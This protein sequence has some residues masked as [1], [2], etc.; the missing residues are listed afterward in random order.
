MVGDAL[1]L[2]PVEAG[3]PFRLAQEAVGH[4]ALTEIRRQKEGQDREL[5]GA[6]YGKASGA[7]IVEQMLDRG[8]LKGYGTTKDA[9][10]A[11]VDA[12]LADPTPARDKLVIAPTNE[13]ARAITSAIRGGLKARGELQG[14]QPVQVAGALA[15]ETRELDL[16]IGDRVRFGKRHKAMGVSNGSI[17]VIEQIEE[18]TKGGHKLA[19]RL[20]S[21]IPGRDGRLVRVDTSKYQDLDHGYAGTVHKA[22]GQGKQTVYWH[23]EGGSADRHLG[24]VAFT[25]TKKTMHAFAS[26][27]GLD[28]LEKSL[29]DWRLKQ[30]AHE[31]APQA[32]SALVSPEQ[33]Q[34]L[35]A[36]LGALL[37]QRS[38]SLVQTPVAM[39]HAAAQAEQAREQERLDQAR[40]EREKQAMAREMAQVEADAQAAWAE[41]ERL[42]QQIMAEVEA[43]KIY[44]DKGAAKEQTIYLETEKAERRE[45]RVEAA[46]REIQRWHTAHPLLG[47]V[48]EPAW[49][50]QKL[51]KAEKDNASA[52][53]AREREK[54]QE[55]EVA[56]HYAE[57]D[58]A[59]QRAD[60]LAPALDK[61]TDKANAAMRA[62]AALREEHRWEA[63][64]PEEQRK[65]LDK[66]RVVREQARQAQ[67]D[68]EP[69][70]VPDPDAPKHWDQKSG[71]KPEQRQTQRQRRDRGW[72]MSM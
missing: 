18:G 59:E 27:H 17:G 41:M 28:K 47:K 64:A 29:D 35:G 66:Q 45:A 70:Q 11:L 3:A 13:G 10:T 43:A 5:A 52:A 65:E 37:K 36:G 32:S 39:D 24:L 50:E 53:R 55:R 46:G 19:V 2:Q 61:A 7:E 63:P 21:E 30:N 60:A 23:A 31:M 48:Y 33:A 68:W 57:A 34:A 42:Q 14:A 8:Q 67:D 58:A 6:F 44:R 22:Q 26:D 71:A 25:R 62:V 54:E 16:A 56:G 20:E 49:I 40:R 38:A 1:Q 51:A 9:R 15:G 4:S 69:M 12:Y 72:G